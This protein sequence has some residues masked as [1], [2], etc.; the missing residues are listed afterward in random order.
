MN[1]LDRTEERRVVVNTAK[2]TICADF[3]AGT[4]SIDGAVERVGSAGDVDESYIDMH[5]DILSLAP[6][7]ACSAASALD[8]AALIEA[9]NKSISERRWVLRE[10]M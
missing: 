10:E 3:I 5:R 4:L 2:A 7:Q 1:Y 8:V 6:R 9:A